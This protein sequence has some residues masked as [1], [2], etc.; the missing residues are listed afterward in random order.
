MQ[1]P[2]PQPPF[3]FTT[4]CPTFGQRHAWRHSDGHKQQT[5]PLGDDAAVVVQGCSPL[6]LCDAGVD[7]FA[8][9]GV[10]GKLKREL[11]L[12]AGRTNSR[13]AVVLHS[14]A[15]MQQTV[16]EHGNM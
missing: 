6:E 14:E 2:P 5:H 12:K 3:L 10:V 15:A 7:H 1:Y 13:Q 4:T 9:R 8:F 16:R 11:D